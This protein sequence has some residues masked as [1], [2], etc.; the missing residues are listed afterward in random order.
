M[1]R[2]ISIDQARDL[3]RSRDELLYSGATEREL[4]NRVVSGSLRRV[5]RG[6]YVD[7]AVWADLWPESR[8]MVRLLAVHR[9]AEHDGTVFSHTSAAVLWEL[10]LFGKTADL[11]HVIIQ[12][13]R[14]SRTEA[15]VRRH[16]LEIA[17]TDIVRRH[18]LRCTSMARTVLDLA[19][20][21][22]AEAAISAADASIRTIAVR[23]SRVD[24]DADSA[25]RE[26]LLALCSPGLRGVRRARWAA[27]FA[28]GRAQLPGESVS[29]LQLDRLGFREVELQV[30]VV[31]SG[32][33]QYFLDFGFRRSR[34]FGEFDGEGKYLESGL[35]TAPTASD[36]VLEEKRRED[37][38]RGVTGWRVV[39]WGST[40]IRT[41]DLLGS[42]LAAFG[43]RPPG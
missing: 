3:V 41:P 5:H 33:A 4:R 32:G 20:T 35:R 23:G 18:G 9:A 37:D 26:E 29:R 13:R 1:P 12:G 14:H 19:R 28:D 22:S 21:L 25:W 31:G 8:Q 10:P 27:E 34:A 36:A 38:V 6:F 15:G 7:G 43:I 2:R 40:Q 17:D 39:R 30:P 11:V 24:A 16:D 42:R